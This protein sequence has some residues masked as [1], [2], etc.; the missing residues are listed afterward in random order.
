MAST[1]EMIFSITS[2]ESSWS[3]KKPR[4][5]S[6]AAPFLPPPPFTASLR[7][8]RDLKSIETACCRPVRGL[9]EKGPCF[10]WVF[11]VTNKPQLAQYD[12]HHGFA[13][14]A[15]TLLG[16]ELA[17]EGNGNRKAKSSPGFL[18]TGS[19]LAK[20]GKPRYAA[21]IKE[22]K[23]EEAIPSHLPC[24]GRGPGHARR[25]AAQDVAKG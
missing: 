5:V 2:S 13:N 14:G 24:Q 10:C 12:Q 8:A 20:L 6:R 17:G 11:T 22:L 23:S 18:R 15:G 4:F 7:T 3:S 21:V 16:G 1:L 9:L 25:W 19:W